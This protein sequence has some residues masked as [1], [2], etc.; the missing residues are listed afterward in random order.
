MEADVVKNHSDLKIPILDM[1]VHIDSEGFARHEHFEKP[2]STKLVLSARSAHS[3]ACKRSVHVTECLRRIQNTS[4][5]ADW[6]EDVVPVLND[7]MGR[8]K[9][10]GYREDQRKHVLLN[11]IA[12]Y[13]KK[14]KLD[15]D[16]ET[17]LN[18]PSNYKKV[19]RAKQKRMKKK[20]WA[21]KGG[22]TAVII[23]AAT[24]D[25]KLAKGLQKIADSEKDCGIWFKIQE[26]GGQTVE[27]MLQR[28]NP[29]AS[30]KCGKESWKKDPCNMCAQSGGGKLCHKCNVMY[31]YKCD[32]CG[33]EY[34]GETSR[35]FYSRDQE[36]MKKYHEK[37]KESFIFN[38]QKECHNGEPPEFTRKVLKSFTDPMSRQISEGV[39]IRRSGAQAINSKLDFY[40][41]S[42][43][44]VRRQV[45][46]G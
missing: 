33:A 46:H 17:P 32:K 11:A 7:Y 41:P 19:E 24:P 25:S 23:V 26:K 14:V 10:A 38:H 44:K 21:T 22:H 27:R 3:G 29:T 6:D 18:R 9:A 36:H 1:K 15:S 43:Y 2:M 16:G 28:P 5:D 8:M 40:Q 13:E 45:D 4:K 42:T 34:I 20:N 39:N 12:I 35:N 30:E 31:K 37:S